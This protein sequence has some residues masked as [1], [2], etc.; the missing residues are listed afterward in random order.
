MTA[1]SRATVKAYFETD[2][3]P[4]QAQFEHLIDSAVNVVDDGINDLAIIQTDTTNYA[5]AFLALIGAA[6]DTLVAH[7]AGD[8]TLT[9]DKSLTG[10][11]SVKRTDGSTSVRIRA[12][13]SQGSGTGA[14]A[15]KIVE[16]NPS[17]VL[18]QG[19]IV[20]INAYTGSTVDLVESHTPNDGFGLASPEMRFVSKWN[21]GG[22]VSEI[23]ANFGVVPDNASFGYCVV[24]VCNRE[25]LRIKCNENRTPI[26]QM[27]NSSEVSAQLNIEPSW[28]GK[29]G[30]R[31]KLN[32]GQTANAYESADSTGTTE[33][34]VVAGGGVQHKLNSG[35]ADPTTS[36]YA[37]GISG[38]WKNTTSGE[39]RFWVND[40]GTMKKSAA[41]TT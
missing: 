39:I 6:D 10:S 9:G 11:L 3:I 27:G 29:T 20:V 40:G 17:L 37:S 28:T 12:F 18:H 35:S 7:L 4:T 19:S 13:N 33:F 25:G 15:P 36:N 5:G 38:W 34:A 1:Q 26:V 31:V 16:V 41:L 32:S 14:S 21:T 22:T 30:V 8:E 24:K 2:D 23:P